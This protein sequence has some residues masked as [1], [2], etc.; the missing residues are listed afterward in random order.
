MCHVNPGK[1]IKKGGTSGIFPVNH[2]HIKECSII[3]EGQFET[4]HSLEDPVAHEVFYIYVCLHFLNYLYS[5]IE[6]TYV[7]LK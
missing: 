5:E 7:Y 3:N 1:L 6:Q 2:I 4:V